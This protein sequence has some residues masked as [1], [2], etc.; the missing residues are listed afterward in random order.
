MN[1]ENDNGDDRMKNN[2]SEV[3]S[4][5]KESRSSVVEEPFDLNKDFVKK[6]TD[7]AV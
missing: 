2:N 7:P 3:E 5:D 6:N 1:D 4:L